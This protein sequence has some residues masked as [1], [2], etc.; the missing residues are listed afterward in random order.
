MEI[1]VAI[2]ESHLAKR[3]EGEGVPMELGIH[4]TEI[5]TEVNQASR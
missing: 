1:G 4:C 2:S 3:G 5:L